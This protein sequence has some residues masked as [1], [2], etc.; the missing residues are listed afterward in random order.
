MRSPLAFA[1]LRVSTLFFAA[2]TA[3]SGVACA[4]KD[5]GWI[6]ARPGANAAGGG[7]AAGD[8]ASATD[9]APVYRDPSGGDGGCSQPNLTCADAC[10]AASSD[11]ENC[12]ACGNVCLGG[13]STCVAGKCAC[14]GPMMD[15][16]DGAGCMDVSADVSNCGACGNVCDPNLYDACRNGACVNSAP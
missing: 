8:E 13:D 1:P 9:A 2:L 14:S 11:R 6:G 4:N 15:Y 10:I 12:G 7:S 16:C 3:A 5:P